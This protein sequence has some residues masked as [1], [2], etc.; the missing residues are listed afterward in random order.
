MKKISKSEKRAI[1]RELINCMIHKGW[2]TPSLIKQQ[3]R[4]EEFFHFGK[5]LKAYK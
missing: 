3:V 2:R 5:Q 4:L 1:R